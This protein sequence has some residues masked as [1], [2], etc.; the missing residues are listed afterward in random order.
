M[1][2]ILECLQSSRIVTGKK[3]QFGQLLGHLCADRKNALLQANDK[4]SKSQDNQPKTDQFLFQVRNSLT[5]CHRLEETQYKYY[6]K[7]IE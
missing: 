2:E 1:F 3:S 5:D 7:D 6:G 4:Y